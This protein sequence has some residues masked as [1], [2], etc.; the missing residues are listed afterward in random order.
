M[1]NVLVVFN[2]Q[3]GVDAAEYEE[4][5][6]TRDLPTARSL[7]SVDGFNVLKCCGMF[8]TDAAAPYQYVELLEV[9]DFEKLGAEAGEGEMAKVAAEFGA[10]ADNPQ[11]I[12]L[13]DIE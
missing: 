2:L 7:S 1:T 4:W 3:E 9:N 12:I 6:R 10:Y 11:F 13:E 5:A 8:G